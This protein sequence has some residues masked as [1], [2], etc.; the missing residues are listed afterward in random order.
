MRYVA[1]YWSEDVDERCLM[2]DDEE[3]E[4]GGTGAGQEPLYRLLGMAVTCVKQGRFSLPSHIFGA[5]PVS[6]ATEQS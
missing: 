4:R 2:A 5:K 6:N 3:E 1:G